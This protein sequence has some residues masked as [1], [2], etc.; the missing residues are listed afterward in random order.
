MGKIIHV[1]ITAPDVGAAADFFAAAF[2]WTTT[3]SPFLPGYLQRGYG[4]RRWHQRCDHEPRLSGPTDHRLDRGRQHRDVARRRRRTGR[5][6]DRRDPRTA[7][8]GPRSPHVGDPTGTVWGLRA[9]R[10]RAA[11]AARLAGGR[12][13]GRIQACAAAAPAGK[14]DGG[15]PSSAVGCPSRRHVNAAITCLIVD[16]GANR[17]KSRSHARRKV[18]YAVVAGIVA[19][20]APAAITSPTF[21]ANP[22]TTAGN[23]VIVW[24]RNAQTA[25]WDVAGQ[26]PQVRAP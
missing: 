5:D 1:E 23:A 12:S 15:W 2:G 11:T 22:K 7:R 6:G 17:D 13:T 8:S 21:A 14:R 4:C 19:A 16:K 26:Q 25:I 10:E 24:D 3:A 20:G 9:S 18:V